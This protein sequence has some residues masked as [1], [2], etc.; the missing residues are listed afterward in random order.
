[1]G[2]VA[3]GEALDMQQALVDERKTGGGT[4][5]LIL[6]EHPHVITLGARSGTARSHVVATPERLQ[7]LGVDLLE[8]G[9]GGDVT[10]HGPGQIVG[11][12][13]LDLRP[14]RKD[15]YRYVRDLE[16]V[17]IR[18]TARH[19]I[20]AG[21]IEG[22]T[23]AWV[24][25]DKIGAIGVRVSRWVTSHGFA[26]NVSTNLDFFNLIVPCG[27]RDRGV[28]SLSR[29]LG[30]EVPVG[31]VEDVFIRE[32]CGVFGYQNPEGIE[33]GDSDDWRLTGWRRARAKSIRQSAWR[34]SPIV[35]SARLPDPPSPLP[36][37]LPSRSI[38]IALIPADSAPA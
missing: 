38:S 35:N 6:L 1:M 13:I 22:L 2:R 14:D 27:I 33:T 30:R 3:Y 11:Y 19:G 24:G 36:S 20:E 37:H 31:E 28:T 23:G 9:R 32:F 16:E 5:T 18:V 7:E 8:T 21:R 10:Y 15:V 34:Q 12:P 26:Y 25:T 4:D 29:L 17:L